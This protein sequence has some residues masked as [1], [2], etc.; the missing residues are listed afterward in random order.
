MVSNYRLLYKVAAVLLKHA[1][2]ASPVLP[3]CNMKPGNRQCD[4]ATNQMCSYKGVA[5]ASMHTILRDS[6]RTGPDTRREPISQY[7]RLCHMKHPLHEFPVL[8][9]WID[10]DDGHFFSVC[11]VPECDGAKSASVVKRSRRPCYH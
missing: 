10:H 1:P 8:L 5:M 6:E 2:A 7:S 9:Y 11:A 3:Y 4:R